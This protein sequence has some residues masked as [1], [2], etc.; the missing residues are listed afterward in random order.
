M[1]PP[2]ARRQSLWRNRDFMALWSGQIVSTLGTRIS[3]T[4]A[5]LLVLAMT[6]SPAD[7]GLIGAAATV[8]Y[9]V[10]HLPAGT[11]VDRW[12]RR[13]I[14]L[15]AQLT[16]CAA[17]AS[18]PVAFWL[19]ALT[20]THLAI[21]VFVQGTCFV[22][23]GVAE[24]AALPKI[25][26]APLL[27]AAIA[28]NEAKGRGAA[29]AGPPLG[30]LLFGIG[31]ALPFV[32]HAISYL[33]ASVALLFVRRDL[34]D[35]RAVPPGSLWRDT[36]A[37]LRWLWGHSL[38][39]AAVVLVA[40]SNLIFAGLSLV[41]V[42]LAR[43]Q[44]ASSTE[45]GLMLGIYGGGGLLGAFAAGWLHHLFTPRSVVIGVNWIWAALLPL[46]AVAPN[47]WALGAIGAA[48]AFIGPMWNVVIGTFQLTLV[49]N[50]LLGR[51]GSASMTV[52]WGVMP[53]GSLGAG[54]LLAEAG[55]VAAVLVLS[56]AM[57][58]TA[59]VA[60]LNRSVRAAPAAPAA[61]G[62]SSA[63]EPLKSDH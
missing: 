36:I 42:V 18:I 12:N 11:L 44:G 10:A 34:Q 14:M 21:A 54:Y 19:G 49:P 46:L 9:L 22:F 53:L 60:T 35:R 56:A 28:Q 17:I 58:V 23:F 48:T 15:A 25:V 62:D 27:P 61:D 47:W 8:P 3:A 45:I 1:T 63:L 57:L 13:R 26:Q 5:P 32:A 59:V 30:G 43:E 55:P 31:H 7:A 6:G 41:L 4:A 33:V 50:E 2:A 37:G 51:V 29:L 40:A 52:G 24:E 38:I 39:R 16:A 20:L